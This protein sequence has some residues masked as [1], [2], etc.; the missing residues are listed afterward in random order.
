MTFPNGY[1]TSKANSCK[2][3]EQVFMKSNTLCLAGLAS[4]NL[5]INGQCRL[6][7]VPMNLKST[8]STIQLD[9]RAKSYEVVDVRN[10]FEIHF[11]ATCSIIVILYQEEAIWPE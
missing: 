1:P 10:N 11:S 6:R 9:S 5:G 7:V 2:D 3:T 8:M 4:D